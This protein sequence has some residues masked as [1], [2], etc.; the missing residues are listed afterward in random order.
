[1]GSDQ[2]RYDKYVAQVR[3]KLIT[4]PSPHQYIKFS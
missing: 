2:I 3:Q 1:M 4:D